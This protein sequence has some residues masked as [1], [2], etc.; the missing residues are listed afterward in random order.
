[1]TAH[2]PI[3][4]VMLQAPLGDLSGFTKAAQ[5]LAQLRTLKPGEAYRLTAVTLQD[6]K[7][8]V[9]PL[10]RQTLEYLVEFFKIRLPFYTVVRYE[11]LRGFLDFYRPLPEELE[12]LMAL[13]PGK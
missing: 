7:V 13:E 9:D 11:P 5:L 2:H 8:P 3:T 4:S 6:I 10:D 12:R 1:M